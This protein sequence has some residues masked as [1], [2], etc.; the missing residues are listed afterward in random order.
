MHFTTIVLPALGASFATATPHHTGTHDDNISHKSRST[1]SIGETE[2]YAPTYRVAGLFWPMGAGQNPSTLELKCRTIG[3]QCLDFPPGAPANESISVRVYCKV[4]KLIPIEV[5]PTFMYPC[6][7]GSRCTLEY[8]AEQRPSEVTELALW[9]QDEDGFL[10]GLEFERELSSWVSLD[11]LLQRVDG[12]VDGTV[13]GAVVKGKR[14]EE[15]QNHYHDDDND[16][17]EDEEQ[18]DHHREFQIVAGSNLIIPPQ[19]FM[20]RRPSPYKFQCVMGDNR[21]GEDDPRI[22]ETSRTN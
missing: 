19:D 17:D 1:A 21:T 4:V 7:L 15:E 5:R 9:T 3:A 20:G 11:G 13:D 2:L 6:P 18:D 10:P 16:D 22:R 14:E 12:V 8:S